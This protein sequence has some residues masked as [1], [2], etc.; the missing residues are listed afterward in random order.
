MAW[1]RALYTRATTGPTYPADDGD[2]R[3]IRLFG[4][5]LPIRASTTLLLVTLVFVLD[6]SRAF[7]PSEIQALGR[8]V[9]AKS[10]SGPGT[11]DPVRARSARGH[12]AA[13][14]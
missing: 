9:A 14:S 10:V 2:R 5:E 1:A 11:R 13:L 4:V 3:E 6:Y 7:I 12:R 8:D